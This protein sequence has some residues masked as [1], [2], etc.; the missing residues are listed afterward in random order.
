MSEQEGI[1]VKKEANFSEWYDQSIYKSE[2][3]DIRYGVKGFQVNLWWSTKMM[4]LMY[5]LYEEELEKKGHKPYIFPTVIPESN[6]TK[7]AEHVQGF[8]AEVF[9]ITQGGSDN[10]KFE[11]RLALRPTSETAIY[12]MFSLWIR[13]HRDLPLKTYQSVQV[14]R[15]ESKMTRPFLR[16][17]EFWWIEA[18]DAFANMEDAEAQIAEDMDTTEK[19]MHQNFGIPFIF[20]KRPE[21]DKFAGAV[22]TFAADSIMPNGKALQQPSTHLLGQKF[23]R[24]FNIKYVDAQNKE[25]YVWQTCYGPA[26]WRMVG[27]IVGLHGDNKGLVVP[28]VIAPYQVV[29]VPIYTAENEKKVMSSAEALSKKLVKQ[30]R[31][32][33]DRRR[34]Y[35]PGWKF[36]E[37]ELKGVPLR[38]EIGPKDIEKN[39]VVLV[40][41]DN[42]K[43]EIIKQKD[44]VKVVCDTLETIQRDLV[45]RADEYFYSIQFKANELNEL[46]KIIKDKGGF[47]K[48]PICSV[49]SE[50]SACG[51]IIKDKTGGAEVRGEKY[52]EKDKPSGKCIAC[53]KKANYYV[54][55]AK[56]Y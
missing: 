39:Q 41:R 2:L 11:E 40:R 20:F 42:G 32:H 17:R 25:E 21:W 43:K 13:S 52:K 19:I 44:V 34:E 27:S 5:H 55:V 45:K 10:K 56:S 30:F 46:V 48:V 38:L 31:T 9:W 53:D 47:V 37:W 50:G 35:K 29:I 54:Y 26:I 12:P 22:Y 14:F 28:P 49:S 16:G 24:P 6:L 33:L 18:H 23:S 15:Y 1:T 8:S 36:N 7:E 3:C 51:E 4:K